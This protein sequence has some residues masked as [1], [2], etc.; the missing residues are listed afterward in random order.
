[1]QFKLIILISA[2]CSFYTALAQTAEEVL[3][4]SIAYH[5]PNN[6]WPDFKG[7]L[8]ITLNMPDEP[9]RYSEVLIDLP[10][11]EFEM[12]V[13]KGN[14]HIYRK[15]ASTM[16]QCEV[17]FN[18]SDNFSEK[19]REKHRL[20]CEQTLKYRNYYTYLYGLPMKLRDPGTII[21]SDV[22]KV[23]FHGKEYLRIK[24]TYE[25]QVG[26]DIW[27][28]YFDPKTLAM[29]AYQF[30]H[31]ESKNDGEYVLLKE[32]VKYKDMRI[33]KIRTWYVNKNDQLLG[34]DELNK[35]SSLK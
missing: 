6:Q 26:S 29:E 31:D 18:G 16:D 5:D 7:K 1:M 33:P 9:D 3:A 28:F 2:V 14:D 30:Y 15:W 32:E 11:E 24:V 27:Y 21:D 25:E 22:R 35:I 10:G 19:Q 34:V 20:T 8:D 12:Y 13:K 23:N 17:I 4:G